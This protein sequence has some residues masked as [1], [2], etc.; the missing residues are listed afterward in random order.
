MAGAVVTPCLGIAGYSGSGK[1]TLIEALLPRLTRRGLRVAVV[2]HDAHQLT[3]DP[4]GKDTARFHDAGAAVVCA[5][6]PTQRFLRTRMDGQI[7]LQ[8]VLVDLPRDLD[9]VLVEGHKDAPIPRLV[10]V[11]PQGAPPI[12][13]PHVVGQLSP[14][15]G[16]VDLAE[17][18]VLAWLEQTWRE[19]PWGIA[20][21]VGRSPPPGGRTCRLPRTGEE[22]APRRLLQRLTAISDR[23]VVVGS[24]APGSRG[25][26][27]VPMITDAPGL[28]G[29]AAG[30]LALLRHDPDR[31][32]LVLSWGMVDFTQAHV[33]W[34]RSARGPGLWAIQPLNEDRGAPE[35][36]GAIYEP[37]LLPLLQRGVAR[38]DR[39]L[40]EVVHG[41]PVGT[42]TI[43][44]ALLDG[45]AHLAVDPS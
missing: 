45:W 11:H 10:C 25:S 42:P 16:R 23:V 9:L 32:W 37:C 33:S 6:D 1:T 19:R 34:L 13:G 29:P 38:G 41:A 15:D 22:R 21:L 35:P 28:E 40:R 4:R 7:T 31:A 44:P 14:G 36:L 26:L 39:S 5:H 8:E 27:E 24:E 43:P 20:V 18:L 30:L 12:E 17:S 3:L 2:K